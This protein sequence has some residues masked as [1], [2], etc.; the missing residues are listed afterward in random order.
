MAFSLVR[1][2]RMALLVACLALSF[3]L[4]APAAN[5]QPIAILPG[6]EHLANELSWNRGPRDDEASTPQSLFAQYDF[7]TDRDAF[8]PSTL[9]ADPGVWIVE[10]SYSFIDNRHTFDTNSFPELLARWGISKRLELR[11]GWNYEVGG[12]GNVVSADEGGEGLEDATS[13][14][15]EARMLYGIKA[16]LTDQQGWIPRSCVILEGFT[17]T[18]GEGTATQ[19]VATVAAGWELIEKM[20]LDGGLRFAT[21]DVLRDDF[22]RWGPSVVLRIPLNE[23]FQVHCEYFGVYT[24]GMA[25][26]TSRTFFSP[27]GHYMLTPK[28]ELGLRMGWGLS[29]DAANYF[30]NAGFGWRW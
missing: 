9:T 18:T 8:T 6:H 17:P 16:D 30:V 4:C 24:Q 25:R 21:G 22:N 23:R 20:R 11:I 7:E 28:L 27:G 2:F 10:A 15:H 13:L 19:V 5:A 12:G 14:E 3:C 1:S 29:P 26:E